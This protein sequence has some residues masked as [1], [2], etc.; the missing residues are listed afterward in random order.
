M[1]LH[2]KKTLLKEMYLL[3]DVFINFTFGTSGSRKVPRFRKDCFPSW[4]PTKFR[5]VIFDCIW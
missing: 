5:A 1:D 3:I 2:V 4:N